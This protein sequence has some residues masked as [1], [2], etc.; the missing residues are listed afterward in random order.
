[1]RK[2]RYDLNICRF[3]NSVKNPEMKIMVSPNSQ[4]L[5]LRQ[6]GFTLMEVLI[7]V[8]LIGITVGVSTNIIYNM[9]AAQR[10]NRL[11]VTLTTLKENLSAAMF[12]DT[13]WLKTINDSANAANMTCLA[14]AAPCP[15]PP[16]GGYN[17]KLL[18]TSGNTV[19]DS[20]TGTG[21]FTPD[22]T[23]CTLP[24]SANNDCPISYTMKWQPVCPAFPCVNPTVKLIAT[25]NY[26]PFNNNFPA[27]INTANYSIPLTAR[28]AGTRYE[29]VIYQQQQ[30]SNTPGGPCNSL[31][32]NQAIRQLGT[33]VKDIGQ[34]VAADSAT[35]VTLKPGT[36]QCTAMAPVYEVGGA[37]LAIVDTSNVTNPLA[38]GAGVIAPTNVPV[39]VMTTVRGQFSFNVNTTL[40]LIQTCQTPNSNN[41]L[42]V[43]IGDPGGTYANPTDVTFAYLECIRIN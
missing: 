41:D 40:E 39:S 18:D 5:K 7:A 35:T 22:G 30:G 32:A 34:N 29:P 3:K 28:G 11:L 1:M 14:T 25:L 12:S 8:A 21:G 2:G 36:Y 31:N 10:R 42:G 38:V 13:A 37:K 19:Y 4:R 16:A 6:N 33:K 43:P 24:A 23:P 15:V 9:T 17:F 20:T 27:A 26:A